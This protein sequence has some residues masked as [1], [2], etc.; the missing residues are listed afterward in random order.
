MEKD[1]DQALVQ[2]ANRGEHA[3]FEALYL[4]HRDWAVGLAYRLTGN[5]EDALDVLQEVFSYFWGKF[6]G[7]T[8]QSTVRSFL[9]PAIRNRSLDLLRERSKESFT[10]TRSSEPVV[11]PDAGCD[12]EDRIS[13][14]GDNLRVVVRLRF[15]REMKLDEIAATLGVPVGTVKSRLHNALR[16]LREA[17]E[18]FSGRE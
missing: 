5:R 2:A 17:R 11:A 7:F 4:R 6:P 18:D 10:R 8:L 3:A 1:D 15:V 13:G 16:Q 12:F 9:Y 14:L